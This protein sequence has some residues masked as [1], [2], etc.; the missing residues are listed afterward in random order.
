MNVE[1]L[2]KIQAHNTAHPEQLDMEE[3]LSTVCGAV[4]CIAGHACLLGG[5]PL[6]KRWGSSGLEIDQDEV[7]VEAESVLQLSGP[8]SWRLFYEEWPDHQ[9]YLAGTL[10]YAYA[11]NA[12]IDRFIET[13]G[14]E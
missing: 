2:R 13:D 9:S 11:V 8:Q 10:E 4:G 1:L 12:R 5:R 7:L 6:P 14:A 3:V